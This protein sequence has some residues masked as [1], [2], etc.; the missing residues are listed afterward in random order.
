[1]K[2]HRVTV[3]LALPTHGAI[4]VDTTSFHVAGHAVETMDAIIQAPSLPAKIYL[5]K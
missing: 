2:F 1:M 5:D 4:S 3:L